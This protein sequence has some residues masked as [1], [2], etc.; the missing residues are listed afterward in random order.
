[1]E[2]AVVDDSQRKLGLQVPG[3][4]WTI[5]SHVVLKGNDDISTR[6]FLT[7]SMANNIEAVND[8][9]QEALS[10]VKNI[11]ACDHYRNRIA[12]RIPGVHYLTRKNIDSFP[13]EVS[14]AHKEADRIAK[15]TTKKARQ[16]IRRLLSNIQNPVSPE[17]WYE[18]LNDKYST[19]ELV[20]DCGD[21]IN[22]TCGTECCRRDIPLNLQD[23]VE[24][25]VP[26]ADN[27]FL[28]AKKG[29][30]CAYLSQKTGQCSIWEKRPKQCREYVCPDKFNSNLL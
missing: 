23:L 13:E 20:V 2:F 16:Q 18:L 30:Y 1:M 6:T 3:R 10:G 17:E 4:D 25:I 11:F 12:G 14:D 22:R 27:P 8:F 21:T 5:Y 26:R 15:E 24:G 7:R 29:D 28:I 19:R 9:L